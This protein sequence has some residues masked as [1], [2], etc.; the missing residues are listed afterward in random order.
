MQDE[1]EDEDVE[2]LDGDELIEDIDDL[3]DYEYEDE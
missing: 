3:E 2:I 1:G